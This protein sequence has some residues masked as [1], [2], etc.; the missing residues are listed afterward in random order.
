MCFGD[1]FVNKSLFAS[2]KVDFQYFGHIFVRASTRGK[3][4][5]ITTI[6]TPDKLVF[7]LE[8]VSNVR[9]FLFEQNVTQNIRP[10]N[11]T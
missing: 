4:L 5:T 6:F 1:F 9:V 2:T 7:L 3:G 8:F 10:K 11:G